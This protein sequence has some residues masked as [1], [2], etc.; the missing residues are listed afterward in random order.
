MDFSSSNTEL[1][2]IIVQGGILCVLV[3]LGNVLRRKVPI[4]RRSLLPTAV[5][6]GFAGLLL[7]Q[8]GL[9]PLDNVFLESVNYHMIAI[10][11]I[12]LGL[13]IPRREKGQRKTAAVRDGTRTGLF[14]VSNYLIQGVLGLLIM[15]ALAATFMPGLFR[16]GGL[17]LPM[18]YG[19]G[20][21][22][23]NNI[24][25]LY[26]TQFGFTGGT[27]FG[28]GIATMGFLW[29]CIGG[30][31]FLN[32]L[33]RR[34][35]YRRIEAP[36]HQDP[37]VEPV[38]DDGE[39]PLVEAVDKFT[40]QIAMVIGIYL[41]TFLFSYGV[42][43]LFD[44]I[45][46]LAG[47]KKTIAPLIWGFNFLIGSSMAMGMRGVLSGLRKSGLM[48]RQY[49][50]NYLLNRISGFAFDMMIVSSICAIDI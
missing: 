14:I 34:G 15:I 30:I 1:W 29:A 44:V 40:I 47:A 33:V 39:I 25:S 9:L 45:P 26:E 4:L 50:N 43:K 12:A 11:F 31:I 13:R 27:T 48:T 17:L 41:L 10:G 32:V 38:A 22:Q 28:L 3:L 24:G 5:I 16:A 35:K 23:A 42:V 6:G 2:Q 20:P 7:K 21:G 8:T 46:G 36:L 19:Q 18:G 37:S 49:P